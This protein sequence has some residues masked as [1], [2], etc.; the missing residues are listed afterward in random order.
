MDMSKDES[1]RSPM[2]AQNLINNAQ[3]LPTFIAVGTT[4]G[5]YINRDDVVKMIEEWAFSFREPI[6][7]WKKIKV[8]QFPAWQ[9]TGCAQVNYIE[10]PRGAFF[11]PGCG[12][13]MKPEIEE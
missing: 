11:C 2:F 4:E 9:C 1:M 3:T 6:H 8:G 12:V 10:P 13:M 5:H 7:Y